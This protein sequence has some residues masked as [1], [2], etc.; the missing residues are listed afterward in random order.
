MAFCSQQCDELQFP[1]SCSSQRHVCPLPCLPASTC[2]HEI[3]S[4]PSVLDT[5]PW[6]LFM[7][8]PVCAAVQLLAPLARCDLDRSTLDDIPKPPAADR[9]SSQQ[10]DSKLKSLLGRVRACSTFRCRTESAAVCLGC[11][12]LLVWGVLCLWLHVPLFW[13]PHLV[14]HWHSCPGR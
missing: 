13:G 3:S 6:L 4:I 14:K 9:Q 1:G 11:S 7:R 12:V 2:L 8:M 10:H 5:Q